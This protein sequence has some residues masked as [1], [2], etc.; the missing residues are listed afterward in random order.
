MLLQYIA[1]KKKGARIALVHSDTEFGRDP[2][3]KSEALAKKLGLEVVEKIVTP[4]G[5]FDV[6][7]EVLKLRRARPEA[8]VWLSDPT[9][10]NHV[11]LI[12]SA[13]LKTAS[14][15]YF[16]AATGGGSAPLRRGER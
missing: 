3:A 8:T 9:W 10:P 14:Y 11:P 5:S 13:G 12:G 7:A 6:S 15:P 1:A 2:I 4:P 16:D